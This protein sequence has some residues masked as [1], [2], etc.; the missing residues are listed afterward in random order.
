MPNLDLLPAGPMVPNPAEFLHSA[1]FSTLLRKLAERYDRIVID[2]P[3]ASIVSDSAILGTQVDGT[4]HSVVLL[5][6]AAEQRP[7]PLPVAQRIELARP[8]EGKLM[9]H[10]VKDKHGR[11]SSPRS[12]AWPRT[13]PAWL[14]EAAPSLRPVQRLS[15]VRRLA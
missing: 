9:V 12:I 11:V 8:S 10:V 6:D 5:T 7:L 14:N 4:A 15:N 13:G 2:S 1:A 3:P